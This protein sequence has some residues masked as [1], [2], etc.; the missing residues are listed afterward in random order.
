M[1]D[2]AAFP[3]G[4]IRIANLLASVLLGPSFDGEIGWGE[5]L[6]LFALVEDDNDVDVADDV[7]GGG[8]VAG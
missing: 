7:K 3:S 1:A 4:R 8:E 5:A 2:S 6:L